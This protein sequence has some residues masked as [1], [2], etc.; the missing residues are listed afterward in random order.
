MQVIHQETIRDLTLKIMLDPEPPNPREWDNLGTMVCRHKRYR[1][2]DTDQL[3]AGKQR[4]TAI[5]LPLYLYDHSGITMRTRPFDCPWDS[6]QV[7]CIYVLPD[8][9]KREYGCK[10]VTPTIRAK[11]LEVL[12]QE[13][14]TYDQYLRGECYGYVIERDGQHLDSCWG[15]YQNESPTADDSYVLECA[16]D[17]ANAIEPV[18][19]CYV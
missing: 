10:R 2:G 12:E 6:G 8:E 16:R 9:V 15:I 18:E 14:K 13:V 11:V 5:M 7:G 4:E 3:L 17:A 1:L 19:A